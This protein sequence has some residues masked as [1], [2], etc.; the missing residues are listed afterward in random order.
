MRFAVK[1]LKIAVGSTAS[2][3]LAYAFG[4]LNAVSAGIITLLTVQDTKKDTVKIALKRVLA[5]FIAYLLLKIIFTLVAFS[6]PAF[7]VFL[8]LFAG[9]CVVFQMQ[10]ALAMNAVLATHYLLEQDMS[11]TMLENEAMLLLI[12]TSV[13][14]GINMFM[15][16]SVAKIRK[17]QIMIEEHFKLLFTYLADRLVNEGDDHKINEV[18]LDLKNHIDE[19]MDHAF[20]NDDNTFFQESKYYMQYMELR[21]HQHDILTD[22]YEKIQ[23]LTLT[24]DYMHEVSEFMKQIA[25]E[26][27]ETYN[28]QGLIV[29][30]GKLMDGIKNSPLPATREEFENRAI[31]YMIFMNLKMF[32]KLKRNFID[33]LTEE[34]KNKYWKVSG[35]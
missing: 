13:G 11:L 26:L 32:I 33:E 30:Q 1:V 17:Q 16:G 24:L 12:G 28:T 23:S 14:I 4:L 22:T 10:D 18:F 3:L 27:H 8:L 25:D 9:I 34:Q 20:R 5:F 2:I 19:G 7:G 31:L 29:K 35:K 6:I 21:D 15:P